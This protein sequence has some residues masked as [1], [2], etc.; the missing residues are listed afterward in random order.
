MRRFFLLSICVFSE[1]MVYPLSI[2]FFTILPFHLSFSPFHFHLLFC[3]V[4]KI[5]TLKI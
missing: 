4:K 3:F 2:I 5:Q 1:I